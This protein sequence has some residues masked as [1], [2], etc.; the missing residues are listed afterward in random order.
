MHSIQI[1]KYGIIS[2]LW[3]REY[4]FET[5]MPPNYEL[6]LKKVKQIAKQKINYF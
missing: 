2:E 5:N 1:R 4:E 6:N 3:E